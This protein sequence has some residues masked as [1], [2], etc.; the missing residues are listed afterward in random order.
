MLL[1]VNPKLEAVV[2]TSSTNRYL[3]PL[4]TSM[5][6]HAVSSART[7]SYAVWLVSIVPSQA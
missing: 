3:P 6:R 5:P 1:S 7:L 4:N 2:A